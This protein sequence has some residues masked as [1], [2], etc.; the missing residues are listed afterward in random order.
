MARRDYTTRLPF[1]PN[2]FHREGVAHGF[3]ERTCH[4]SVLVSMKQTLVK[5]GL[6]LTALALLFMTARTSVSAFGCGIEPVGIPPI[7]VGC[8]AMKHV[9]ACDNK[10]R[11]A[12]VWECVK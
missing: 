6:S 9:C 8:K 11:C 2:R 5:R 7:V 1:N 10:G 3:D 4:S 12:W